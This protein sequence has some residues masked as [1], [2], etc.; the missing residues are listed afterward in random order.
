MSRA[1]SLEVQ[2]ALEAY[3]GVQGFGSRKCLFW[4]LALFL[5][6]VSVSRAHGETAQTMAAPWDCQE[7]VL[8]QDK[9]VAAWV[10]TSSTLEPSCL[11]PRFPTYTRC[12]LMQ[13]TI[14]L[15]LSF[16]TWDQDDNPGG[17]AWH[18][19]SWHTSWSDCTCHTPVFTCWPSVVSGKWKERLT[20]VPSDLLLPDFL[21]ATDTQRI[22]A[23][24]LA[25]PS[26]KSSCACWSPVLCS[27]L[28]S[29]SSWWPTYS[30]L[31]WLLGPSLLPYTMH[32]HV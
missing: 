24:V 9:K 4:I 16:F 5:Q 3:R 18:W 14:S 7:A 11:G 25:L 20:V 2:T 17:F 12:H 28:R 15:G 31:A 22:C 26:P 30:G 6:A 32:S 23:S 27:C 21:A 10:V 8:G 13:V 29:S 1:E 19:V